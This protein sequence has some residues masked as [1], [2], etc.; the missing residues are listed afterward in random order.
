MGVALDD[1]DVKF[2]SRLRQNG[3]MS[4]REL[5]RVLGYSEATVRRRVN[6]LLGEGYIKIVALADPVRLGYTVDVIM[7][8]EV[9]PGSVQQ[10]ADAFADHEN[11]RA[12]TITSGAYD[13]IVAAMF[14]SNEE[15]LEF[16]SHDLGEIPGIT[17]VQTS[18]SLK[19]VKRSFD[20][21][22]ESVG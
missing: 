11:V 10:A 12:V 3:R 14:R 21:F 8:V 17:R 22:P 15:L 18:N 7:G 1:L 19:V 6:S 5:A 20:F 9:Q 13:L 4:N 16:T 2:I